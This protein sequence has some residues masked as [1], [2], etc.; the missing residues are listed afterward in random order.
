MEL[1]ENYFN[2]LTSKLCAA[3]IPEQEAGNFVE[4]YR[5]NLACG[6]EVYDCFKEKAMP[7]DECFRTLTEA[8][9]LSGTSGADL[10]V[11]DIANYLAIPYQNVTDAKK[12]IGKSFGRS[13]DEVEKDCYFEAEWLLLSAD[14]VREFAA[15]LNSTFSDKVLVWAIFTK[16]ALLGFEIAQQRIQAV[17]TLLGIDIGEKVIRNDVRGRAWLFYR[18]FTDPIA[19]L[20]YML[21]CRLTPEKVLQLLEREPDILYEYKEGRK[22]KYHHKQDYIDFIIRRFVD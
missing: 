6:G 1:T 3:G 15:Y 7:S 9:L 2:E 18:W 19:C 21:E 20:E 17:I 22:L 14:T 12:A 4:G 11:L 13:V 5:E 16:A 10:S 8:V